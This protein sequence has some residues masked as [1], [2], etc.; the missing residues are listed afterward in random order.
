[1]FHQVKS[2]QKFTLWPSGN[3]MAMNNPPFIHDLPYLNI[4]LPYFIM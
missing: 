4:Y 1:M 3:E 2:E